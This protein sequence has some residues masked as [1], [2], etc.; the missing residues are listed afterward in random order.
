[1]NALPS[2]NADVGESFGPWRMGDDEAL[3][4]LIDR[5]NIACGLHAGDPLV[6][7]R[8]VDLCRQHGVAVGAHPG[9]PDLQGFGRRP[10]TLT[11]AE[12]RAYLLYQLGA[13]TAFCRLAGVAL[14][15]VKPHG[16]LYTQAAD[17]PSLA[18]T[19]VG[20]IRAFDPSL[21]L[22]V[23]ACSQLS[24][25]AEAAGQP[26]LIEIFAD[27]GYDETGRLLPR[28]KPGALI[29]D[30]QAVAQRVAAMLQAGGLLTADGRLIPTRIDTLCIHSDTPNAVAIARRLRALHNPSPAATS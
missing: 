29:T 10:L 9:Y 26:H 21:P 27:R 1:M 28:G 6:M 12:L 14:A 18:Q 30:P 22:I 8:T 3:I 5:A 25:A 7:Q 16:A 24:Q 23:P 15:H 2:L 20:A 11:A 17:D 13:L 4:P 19:L